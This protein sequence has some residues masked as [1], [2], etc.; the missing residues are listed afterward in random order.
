MDLKYKVIDNK[1]FNI[2]DILRSEFG[3]SSRLYLKLK[4]ANKI[5]LNGKTVLSSSNISIGDII[6]V[7]LSFEEDNSNIV[8]TKMELDII[9]EDKYILAI[10]KPAG[11]AVHPSLR[12][13]ENS[14]SNGVKYY[15]DSVNLHRKI[16]IVNRLDKDTSGS[17]LFAK[18]EY[19]QENLIR[20]MKND[21]FKKEYLGIVN[22]S[23]RE[24]FWRN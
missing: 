23:F 21:L 13:F 2:K 4:N 14:L 24:K 5:Y 22:R 11:I 10:N 9:Y 20:Q 15:F 3:I 12:H 18:N 16:R 1:Y 6:E 19:I 17:V 7:D 8:P